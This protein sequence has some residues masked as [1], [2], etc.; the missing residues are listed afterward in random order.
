[1]KKRQKQ[2]ISERGRERG[3]KK[4]KLKNKNSDLTRLQK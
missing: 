2:A 1:M 4:R 3:E